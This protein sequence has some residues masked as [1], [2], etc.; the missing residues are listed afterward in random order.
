[1]S[2]GLAGA[3][4]GA[5]Q[6]LFAPRWA[7]GWAPTRVLYALAGLGTQLPRAGAIGDAY[8]APDMVFSRGPLY[9]ADWVVLT[10]P[11]AWVVWAAGVAGLLGLGWGGRLARPGLWLWLVAMTVLVSAEALNI[12]AYDR[13]LLWTG[14]CLAFAPI[15]ERDLDR[16][17]CS[18]A[19]RWALVVVYGGLYGSTGW[20]KALL[21]P[22]WW[23]GQ[24]LAYHLVHN[25]FG[26]GPLAAWVSTRAW[27]TAPMSWVTVLFEAS[28]PFLVWSRRANPWLLA[29]GVGMHLGIQVLMDVGP[30][31]FVA[32]A[33]YPAL[34]NP[35][36]ALAW[37]GRARQGWGS[38]MARVATKGGT[39]AESGSA[40]SV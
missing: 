29:V 2:L 16:R 15:G 9:L 19:P 7:G 11:T 34:L 20:L 28:F 22:A 14:L 12:K 36:V 17:W 4:G 23:D 39:R 10:P 35:E 3:W 21:E 26:G 32:L 25:Q 38:R 6:R 27:L 30:F 1:M 8:A 40:S 18:P 13:L 33:A 37:A 31:S 5:M 24:A